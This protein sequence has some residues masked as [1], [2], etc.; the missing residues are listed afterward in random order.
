MQRHGTE[1][2]EGW[3][4]ISRFLGR[5][6]RTVQLWERERGL[7]VQRIPG[8]PGQTVFAEASALRA[9]LA[10]SEPTTAIETAVAVAPA[11]APG[12][13]VL[14]FDYL[15]PDSGMA[16][17]GDALASQLVSRLAAVDLQQLRVLS[18][19]TA[20]AT[21]QQA[22]TAPTL[23][24]SLGVQYFVEG[25]VLDAGS[26]WCIEV[27]LVDAQH[28]RV[29]FADRF[30]CGA[31][32][33]LLLEAQ[34]AEAVCAHLR[35]Y[36][37]GLLLEPFWN[38]ATDPAAYLCFL[39]AAEGYEMQSYESVAL[40]AERID[41]ALRIDPKFLPAEPLRLRIASRQLTHGDTTRDAAARLRDDGQRCAARAPDLLQTRLMRAQMATFM[42]YDWTEVPRQLLPMLDALPAEASIRTL[43]A[44]GH[45]MQRQSA[46]TRE[47]LAPVLDLDLSANT[48]N[49]VATAC[50]AERDYAGALGHY[51]R[52]LALSPT[53][54]YSHL[55]KAFVVG[56]YQRDTRRGAELVRT[57]PEPVR[58]RYGSMLG[59][60]FAAI[61]GNAK[62]AREARA[63]AA[64]DA[65]AGNGSWFHVACIDGLLG[66]AGS[67]AANVAKS[68][69]AFDN[70]ASLAAVEP[71]LDPV[72]D[73]PAMRAVIGSMNL[74]T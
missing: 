40:A 58:R 45:A 8:G 62:D 36:R 6:V 25:A 27:R 47:L 44:Y 11:R 70:R 18:W 13:L 4:S 14:P 61:D 1:R 60:C 67:C 5:G 64:D 15:A 38:G 73:H 69:D 63:R 19:A 59:G 37:T 66:D 55:K 28:D 50:L 42:D 9:W 35:L 71:C 48:C 65:A 10:G 23:A 41:E 33:I 31:R 57:M 46:T 54:V 20:K 49:F 72:R 51:D 7:P 26:R 32:E 22:A 29:V 3:K 56:A 16:F 21:R 12:L 24:E 68:R 17:V 2:L 43:L 52:A 30:A 39:Q 53:N 34:V 74:P